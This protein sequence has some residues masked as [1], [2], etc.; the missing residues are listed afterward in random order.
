MCLEYQGGA[1]SYEI[2]RKY[3]IDTKTVTRWVRESGGTVRTA[4]E[5]IKSSNAVALAAIVAS[6]KRQGIAVDDWTGTVKEF[7]KLFDLCPDVGR[8]RTRVKRRDKYTC[9]L[10]GSN[11]KSLAVHHIFP[12]SMYYDLALETDNGITLC[13][14]CHHSTH[15]KELELI[16]SFLAIIGSAISIDHPHNSPVGREIPHNT[17]QVAVDRSEYE[18][19]AAQF[20]GG[21]SAKILASEYGVT[22]CTIYTILRKQNIDRPGKAKFNEEQKQEIIKLYQSGIG[23]C[24]LGQMFGVDNSTILRMLAAK[25]IE[26]SRPFYGRRSASSRY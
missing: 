10:C 1:S 19:I 11:S 13:R 4:R 9:R 6:A 8:W 5:A 14:S 23:S 22:N 17:I 12:F 21:K 18:S 24:M 26:R 15:G 2:A 7:R 16:P 3:G 20:Q 25:G